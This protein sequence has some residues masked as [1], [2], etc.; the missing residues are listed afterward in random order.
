MEQLNLTIP[1]DDGDSVRIFIKAKD[2][3]ENDITDNIVVHVDSSPPELT[4]V[5]LAKDGVQ[6]LAVHSAQELYDME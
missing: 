3:L 1:R 6:G 5:G 2:V 4:I